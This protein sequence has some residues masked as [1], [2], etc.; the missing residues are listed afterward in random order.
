MQSHELS[1]IVDRLAH[2][3]ERGDVYLSHKEPRLGTKWRYLL[4]ESTS[5]PPIPCSTCN[6]EIPHETWRVV[7]VM[8]GERFEY[9][10][11]A[12][13]YHRMRE[14]P[15]LV[16][17]E[18]D[19]Q[20]LSLTIGTQVDYT[21][22]YTRLRSLVKV[23]LQY[24]TKQPRPPHIYL[25]WNPEKHLNA[26]EMKQGREAELI[27]DSQEV[28]P[29]HIGKLIYYP[30]HPVRNPKKRGLLLPHI[31]GVEFTT[32]LRPHGGAIQQRLRTYSIIG[33][34][35]NTEVTRVFDHH[36]KSKTDFVAIIDWDAQRVYL[37]PWYKRLPTGTHT[38]EPNYVASIVLNS[39][40]RA[41]EQ[42]PSP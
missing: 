6:L 7:K 28:L 22:P 3:L 16:D 33:L 15:E 4:K 21:D 38:T 40:Y 39:V 27:L 32:P 12:L 14:H 20:K 11:T 30:Q 9:P 25:Q 13:D 42:H 29:P 1:D 31:I 41:V 23:F 35:S 19:V 36:Y 18:L 2:L 34:E 8:D 10:I 37:H 26:S 17:S 24:C 5:S